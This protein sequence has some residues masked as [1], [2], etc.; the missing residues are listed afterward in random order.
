M[1]FGLSAALPGAGSSQRERSLHL[2]RERPPGRLCPGDHT[3][4][5]T[6]ADDVEDGECATE[7]LLDGTVLEIRA[8][9]ET[10]VLRRTAWTSL[11]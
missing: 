9:G 8:A 10:V 3:A 1:L 6:E 11:R 2:R 4:G 7:H 5:W